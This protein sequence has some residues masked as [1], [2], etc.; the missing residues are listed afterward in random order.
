M[1]LI[2][3]LGEIITIATITAV[4]TIIVYAVAKKTRRPRDDQ[5]PNP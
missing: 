3:W 5:P 4:V 1:R 2:I